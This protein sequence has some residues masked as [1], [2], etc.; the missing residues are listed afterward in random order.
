MPIKLTNRCD[1]S[2]HQKVRR[3]FFS[4]TW[5]WCFCTSILSISLL[6]F[7][8]RSISQSRGSSVSIYRY[9]T[10]VTTSIVKYLKEKKKTFLIKLEILSFVDKFVSG[11]KL[12]QVELSR[13]T[14]ILLGT[15]IWI[16]WTMKRNVFL[17]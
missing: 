11:Y 9:K 17:S 4:W 14:Y 5:N 10:T 15:W 12:L 3:S 1:W 6:K 2:G 16:H 7:L 8:R 13:F